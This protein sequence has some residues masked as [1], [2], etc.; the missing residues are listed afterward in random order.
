MA[1]H[2][3]TQPARAFAPSSYLVWLALVGYCAL[4]KVTVT[5]LPA[6]FRSVE[7]AQ[8]FDWPFL[9]IWL[10]A[11]WIGIWSARRAG[12]PGAWDPRASNH[13][14]FTIPIAL[15][16][17]LGAPQVALDLA[18]GYTAVLAHQHGLPR[19]NIDFPASLLIYP[20]GAIIVE[21]CYRLLLVPLL[22]WLVSTW[23]LR[24][25]AR[26]GVFWTLAVLTSLLEPLSQDLDLGQFGAVVAALGF[27]LDFALNLAQ[28]AVFGRSGFLAAIA[29]RG[30]FYLVWHVAYVH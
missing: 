6:T 28:A 24:G 23:L 17:L 20:G 26:A 18:T 11:G 14:R 15:G 22:L 7:Q 8:V 27:G 5:L 4:V 2:D 16:L 13:Q 1:A 19:E 3:P 21:V 25:R 12:L 10:V 29:L 9:G 30:A